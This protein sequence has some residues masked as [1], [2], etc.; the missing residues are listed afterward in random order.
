MQKNILLLEIAFCI[1]A[2]LLFS[3]RIEAINADGKNF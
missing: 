1:K 2:D 3:S